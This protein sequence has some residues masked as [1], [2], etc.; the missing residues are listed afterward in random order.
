MYSLFVLLSLAEAL[1]LR[2]GSTQRVFAQDSFLYGNATA[3]ALAA[4][5]LAGD[6]LQHL[7]DHAYGSHTEISHMQNTSHG[8]NATFKTLSRSLNKAHGVLLL[9]TSTSTNIADRVVADAQVLGGRVVSKWTYS[10]GT[11]S[12]VAKVNSAVTQIS[13]SIGI[14]KHYAN[15]AL[16][17]G[18]SGWA[19]HG[20]PIRTAAWSLWT[21]GIV[22]VTCVLLLCFMTQYIA[23]EVRVSTTSNHSADVANHLWRNRFIVDIG[24]L[25]NPMRANMLVATSISMMAKVGLDIGMSGVLIGSYWAFYWVG[26]IAFK[27]RGN[28]AEGR[29]AEVLVV[30]FVMMGSTLGIAIVA[31]F[32]CP[33]TFHAMCGFQA[34]SGLGASYTSVFRDVFRKRIYEPAELTKA[35]KRKKLC[36]VIGMSCGPLLS[37]ASGVFG[38]EVAG[39]FACSLLFCAY[40]VGL[41]LT[42]PN[43]FSN[44]G[45]KHD[46][47]V[48]VLLGE[49]NEDDQVGGSR[50]A[51]LTACLLYML[52]LSWCNCCTETTSVAILMTE[53]HYDHIQSGIFVALAL[54]PYIFADR[55]HD[56]IVNKQILT[57]R[58][59][60]R[61]LTFIAAFGS[62]LLSKSLSNWASSN[63]SGIAFLLAG[64]VL[65]L[66]SINLCEGIL[67][68]WLLRYSNEEGIWS[69][70]TIASTR[71]ILRACTRGSAPWVSR[72]LLERQSRD[73]VT[74]MH[75]TV[76][77]LA[78]CC[79][80]VGSTPFFARIKSDEKR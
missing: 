51:M 70:S 65:M 49:A 56:L 21:G 17:P 22:L 64:D 72:E 74:L 59:C 79:F 3:T 15:A 30:N 27:F 13:T 45:E 76:L 47:E 12:S 2:A 39:M 9:D 5:A 8:N 55:L 60:A 20:S 19:T 38:G 10:T 36:H 7:A 50:D 29:R 25:L 23:R 6:V 75:I 77:T 61:I 42:F 67:L 68:G 63:G 43:D 14:E 1:A 18:V 80:E 44:L 35:S 58:N 46:Q 78:F 16:A 4:T 66:S 32:P 53:Y 40:A 73:H 41:Y 11:Q 31:L 34:I 28:S 57:E 69:V 54:L 52:V 71:N 33:Y 48:A 37:A 26:A 62:L 24:E